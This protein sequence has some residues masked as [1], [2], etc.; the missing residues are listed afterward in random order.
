MVVLFGITQEMGDGLRWRT[1]SKYVAR[2]ATR[3]II[4]MEMVSGHKSTGTKFADRRAPGLYQHRLF[5]HEKW[6]NFVDH[7]LE[8]ERVAHVQRR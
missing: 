2:S 6:Y 3:P 5:L 7:R 4:S 1:I 8:K